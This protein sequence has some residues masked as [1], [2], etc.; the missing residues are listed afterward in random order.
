MI[1]SE[2]SSLGSAKAAAT[3]VVPAASEVRIEVAIRHLSVSYNKRSVLS[4]VNLE[5][6]ERE[7]F[8]IVGPANS[9]KTSFL[10]VLNVA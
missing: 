5:I 9:G 8:G 6:R 2:I 1:S 4:G 7:I 10:R 3:A